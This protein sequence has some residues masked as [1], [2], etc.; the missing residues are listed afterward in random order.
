MAVLVMLLTLWP[1]PEQSYRSSL[2]PVTCLVCGDQGMQDVLQNVLMLIPFGLALGLAGARASRAALLG[3]LLALTVESLQYWVVTGRDASLSDLLTNTLGTWLGA[4]L[5]P[6]LPTLLRPAVQASRRLGVCAA[7]LWCVLWVFGAWVIGNNVG[8]GGWRGRVANDFPDVPPLSGEVRVASVDGVPLQVVPA[9]LPS[10]VEAAFARQAFVLEASIR[11]SEPVARRENV[12][13]VIDTR[14]DGSS[15]L[16]H[17]V[18]VVNRAREWA[19][20]HFRMNAAGLRLRTP[21]FAFGPVFQPGVDVDLRVKRQEGSLVGTWSGPLAGQVTFRLAPELL[22]SAV[23]PR[24]PSPRLLWR[25]EVFLWA[26]LLLGAA[27]YW[28]SRGR[29]WPAV[30]GLVVLAVGTQVAVPMVFPV[31]RQSTLGWF[32]LFGGLLLGAFIGLKSL[33]TAR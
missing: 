19:V 15:Y 6:Q 18:L 16:N 32:M 28:A 17:V 25:V 22:Y 26:A 14:N 33:R 23:A 5:A 1:L 21:S 31:A 3:F 13:T 12:I 27:G 30:A 9:A 20:L 2:S 7:L 24:S 4:S 10:H 11:P 29:S 8:A